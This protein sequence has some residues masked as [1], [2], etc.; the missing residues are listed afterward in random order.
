MNKELLNI[1]KGLIILVEF[2]DNYEEIIWDLEH[3]YLEQN[4]EIIDQLGITQEEANIFINT[5]IREIY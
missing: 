5:V 3:K 1:L 2:Y 4:K